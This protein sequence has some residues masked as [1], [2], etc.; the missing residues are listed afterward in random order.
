M[1]LDLRQITQASGIQDTFSYSGRYFDYESYV[2]FQR[3]TSLNVVMALVSVF[4]VILVVT[5]NATISLFVLLCVALVDLYLFS[6]MALWN[7][8]LNSVSVIN[9]VIAIGLAVDYS[10]HIGHAF[11]Q[12]KAPEEDEHGAEL[13]DFEKRVF[14]TRQALGSV[15]SSVFHGAFSTF[16][17]IVVLA[18]SSSYVFMA[19]FK[20]WFGIIVFGVANGFVL[21][22]VM[23]SL[24]GPLTKQGNEGSVNWS[25]RKSRLLEEED[26]SEVDVK[27]VSLMNSIQ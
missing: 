16:L 20:M 10:A 14:K 19:F 6:L 7:V 21:L 13:S 22:P 3:E 12:A 23:L 24:C 8:T 4:C 9:V 15:G 2:T 5:A 17:A 26:L 18:P 25:R 27:E 1:L 11:L